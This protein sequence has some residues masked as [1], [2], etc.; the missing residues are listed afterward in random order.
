[1][2]ERLTIEA[3][4]K[5]VQADGAGGRSSGDTIKLLIKEASFDCLEWLVSAPTELEKRQIFDGGEM[6]IEI[7]KWKKAPWEEALFHH[8]IPHIVFYESVSNS[9]SEHTLA[10]FHRSLTRVHSR[11]P[12][13]WNLFIDRL[14]TWQA[15]LWGAQQAEAEFPYAEIKTG[16]ET[17]IANKISQSENKKVQQARKNLDKFLLGFEEWRSNR[18]YGPSERVEPERPSKLIELEVL[19]QPDWSLPDGEDDLAKWLK[20]Q[21][22]LV[23]K[24]LKY[25]YHVQS[26]LVGIDYSKLA[27]LTF[28]IPFLTVYDNSIEKVLEAIELYIRWRNPQDD[29]LDTKSPRS[30]RALGVSMKVLSMLGLMAHYDRFVEI[31]EKR[32]TLQEIDDVEGFVRYFHTDTGL[33]EYLASDAILGEMFAAA[34]TSLLVKDEFPW[35]DAFTS[36]R[37]TAYRLVQKAI[38]GDRQVEL[39]LNRLAGR[40]GETVGK[41]PSFIRSGLIE[42]GELEWLFVIEPRNLRGMLGPIEFVNNNEELL[43]RILTS[44]LEV[45]WYKRDR[46]SLNVIYCRYWQY[47]FEYVPAFREDIRWLALY[48]CHGGDAA[49]IKDWV[50]EPQ[51]QNDMLHHLKQSW[52]KLPLQGLEAIGAHYLSDAGL[53]ELLMDLYAC[54]GDQIWPVQEVLRAF[55]CSII[56]TDH[57]GRALSSEQLQSMVRQHPER[58]ELETALSEMSGITFRYELVEP[59]LLMKN[60]RVLVRSVV[61]GEIENEEKLDDI[62][63]GLFNL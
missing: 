39:I 40:I 19:R 21:A 33:L 16:I 10:N 4:K 11:Y 1:M 56:G 37:K 38:S 53:E 8:L 23:V 20:S 12:D 47:A 9:K 7:K 44:F 58:F 24:S 14:K 25:H 31:L 36:H 43:Q 42:Q 54:R 61:R 32:L 60:S 46:S 34:F 15:W 22:D 45:H 28:A 30:E 27:K 48:G 3:L 51:V 17:Y 29:A 6:S 57:D 5:I 13:D 2:T 49:Y 18:R 41:F 59:G 50:F 63:N 35:E 52:D 26:S 55:G 62:F